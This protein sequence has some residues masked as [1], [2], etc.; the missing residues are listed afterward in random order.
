MRLS[1]ESPEVNVLPDTVL[2]VRESKHRGTMTENPRQR[3]EQHVRPQRDR[4]QMSAATGTENRNRRPETS[5]RREDHWG[6]CCPNISDGLRLPSRLAGELCPRD[7]SPKK[8]AQQP[9]RVGQPH[10]LSSTKTYHR[11]RSQL[12]ERVPDIAAT[13]ENPKPQRGRVSPDPATHSSLGG[14]AKEA[15]EESFPEGTR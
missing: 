13:W 11:W 1:P 10:G 14:V 12:R 7:N 8:A 2:A 3:L 4:E 6:A 15:G 9:S 5:R